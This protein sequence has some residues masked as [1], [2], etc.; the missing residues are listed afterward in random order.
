MFNKFNVFKNCLSL[1]TNSLRIIR[2]FSI[3]YKINVVI[4]FENKKVG[5]DYV[6]QSINSKTI[7]PLYYLR[8]MPLI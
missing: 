1:K 7:G 3:N 5:T 4:Y 8:Y 6:N 2:N